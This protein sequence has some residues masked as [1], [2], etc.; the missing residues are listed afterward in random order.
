MTKP[1]TVGAGPMGSGSPVTRKQLLVNGGRALGAF[2]ALGL[3]GGG[4]AACGGSDSGGGGSAKSSGP[5]EFW[6]QGGAYRTYFDELV[7]PAFQKAHPDIQ[8]KMSFQPTEEIYR[9]SRTALQAGRGPDL[10]PTY[11]GISN[12]LI[13]AGL[14]ADLTP[15]AEKYKWKD[16]LLGWALDAGSNEGKPYSL[17]ME[18][19]SIVL[20]FNKS[21]FEDKGWKPPTNRS[22][23][24]ALAEE[25]QGQGMV[26]FSAGNKDWRPWTGQIFVT[27]FFNHFAGPQ[28]VYD[29][30]TGKLPWTDAVFVDAI[31]LLNSYFKKGWFGGGV[32]KFF[33]TGTEA[34]YSD[35]AKG[36]SAMDIEGLWNL[37]DL[38]KYFEEEGSDW[39][40]VAAP[41]LRDGVPSPL[42]T[43]GIGT[44]VA[45]AAK[46]D[47]AE[48]AATFLDWYY[49]D[50]KRVG[51]WLAKYPGT[52]SIPLTIPED[53]FPSSMDAR[54]RDIYATVSG[55]AGDAHYGYTTYT[56]WPPESHNY[57]HEGMEKVL[58][59]DTTPKE[60]CAR[61]DEIFQGELKKNLVPPLIKPS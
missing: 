36:K 29:A 40:W 51:G 5:V 19:E 53:S 9:V 8:L 35:L 7:I 17:P 41:P 4:L 27:V 47:Q 30:L 22:E 6:Q 58:T 20:Y 28:A 18:Y 52:A 44:S 10:V 61:L 1:N 38:P 60:Y 14:L 3:V 55:A 43:L 46:S 21:L 12:D 24:E 54:I 37:R 16:R 33:S 34:M 32:E 15:Y 42:F 13:R 56:F 49:S 48:A 2:S 26:P 31:E 45:M 39:D 57:T 23:L 50:P 25:V 59:G 11:P